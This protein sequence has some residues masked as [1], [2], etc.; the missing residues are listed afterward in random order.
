MRLNHLRLVAGASLAA[1]FGA[2]A[3]SAQAQTAAALN[4][5]VS[6]AQEGLMEGVLVSARKDGS[7][8]A[9]T[10]VSNDKGE[11]SF[12]AARLEPGRYTISIR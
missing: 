5:Q 11:F 12:P 7:T 1:A 3:L 6:S 10:V 2:L 4:G 9:T 8:I